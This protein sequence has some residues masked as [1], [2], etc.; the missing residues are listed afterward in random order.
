MS[1]DFLDRVGLTLP[2][3]YLLADMFKRFYIGVLHSVSWGVGPMSIG[4]L[5]KNRNG[6]GGGGILIQFW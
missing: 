2:R 4:D 1:I 3:A 6:N 5:N